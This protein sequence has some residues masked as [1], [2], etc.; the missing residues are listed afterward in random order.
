MSLS[1][2]NCLEIMIVFVVKKNEL[3]DPIEEG[4]TMAMTKV[5][6]TDS[7]KSVRS[8][9]PVVGRSISD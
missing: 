6:H 9:G 5:G 1:N 4:Y 3:I 2:V 7:G 8:G